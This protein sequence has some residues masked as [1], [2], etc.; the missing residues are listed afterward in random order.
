M[1]TKGIIGIIALIAV[2]LVVGSVA[3]YL[4]IEKGIPEGPAP[5]DINIVDVPKTGGDIPYQS[6]VPPEPKQVYE[7]FQLYE[8]SRFTFQYP[9]T[10]Q[11]TDDAGDVRLVDS[12]ATT[13]SVLIT[14]K[15]VGFSANFK[16][17]LDSQEVTMAT[18]A[19]TTINFLCDTGNKKS[20]MIWIVADSKQGYGF[21]GSISKKTPT[22][23]AAG[24][25]KIF[26]QVLLSFEIIN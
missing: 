4:Y 2:A 24:Y 14:D 1:N 11:I 8:E 22:E 18:G 16:P 13:S 19:T 15:G 7:G 9:A 21:Y 12:T 20:D 5:L 10:W 3:T 6:I 26:T 17:C 25:I 23:E